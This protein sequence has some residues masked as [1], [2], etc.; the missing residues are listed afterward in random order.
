MTCPENEAMLPTKHILVPMDWSEPSHRAFRLAVSLAREHD[1]RLTLL[2]VVP[3]PALMHGPPQE[4]YL[5]HL[6]E[7]LCRMRPSDP[8]VRVRCLVAEGAPVAAILN[9]TR[10][11][12]CDLIVMG[13]HGRR[14]LNRLLM[15]SLAE[16]V[17]RR[18]P[19]PVL[20]VRAG[21]PAR[22]TG[23]GEALQEVGS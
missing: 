15:G 1:A 13:T 2:H 7:E 16:E 20:T 8:K 10:E 22:L 21:V 19:C 18:A 5:D 3:L 9:A 12:G 14:G 11:S 6:Y 17:V 4:S 23:E